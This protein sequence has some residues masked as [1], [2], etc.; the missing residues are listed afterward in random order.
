MTR[1]KNVNLDYPLTPF[2]EVSTAERTNIIELK[3]QVSQ[4]SS[5]RNI[6][7]TTGS[8][9]LSIVDSE[10]VLALTALANDS[11]TI[12]TAERGRYVPGY[13]AEVGIGVRLDSTT[14]DGTSEARWG[15]FNDENGFG[16][17]VDSTG[18]FV[19]V[20]RNSSD[21][22]KVYQNDWSIDGLDQ[23]ATN[24]KS[25]LT[26]NPQRG[27]IFQVQ[28][29]W[30]GY[31]VIE[32][33]I[34]MPDDAAINGQRT[35]ACH[36]YIPSGGTS[37]LQPN[38]PIRAEI[39]NGTSTTARNFYVAGR[40]YSILGKYNPNRRISS[41]TVVSQSLTAGA[42]FEHIMSVR[43]KDTNDAFNATSVKLGYI[44]VLTDQSAIVRVKTNATPDAT[45]L[46][47]FGAL[48][49]TNTTETVLEVTDVG[50]VSGGIILAEFLVDGT[51]RDAGLRELTSDDFSFDLI[52][53]QP[54]SIEIDTLANATTTVTFGLRE[55]W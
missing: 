51:R 21:V 5:I 24:K 27:N 3:S 14:F 45:A 43:R 32:F 36:K 30:Y 50:T 11:V 15:Y 16:F 55:E 19:F 7:T 12:D 34:V 29:S 22:E 25:G 42:G 9:S 46:A 8:A 49:G 18:I 44:N 2:D 39:D 23:A 20:R 35:V 33:L 40:Q 37:I 6:T 1:I 17:G 28:Y 10:Y 31:G 52:E 54:I 47:G 53:N 26:L 13:G 41:H 4:I 38:L 48:S